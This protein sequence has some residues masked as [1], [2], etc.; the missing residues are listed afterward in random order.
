MHAPPPET[1]TRARH[2][3][4]RRVIGVGVAALPLA[5]LAACGS[6]S[7]SGSAS[8]GIAVEANDT[9]CAPA[10]STGV[11]GTSKFTIKNAGNKVT[12]LYV[13]APGDRVVGEVEQVGPGI[14]RDLTV[15]LQPGSYELACKPG[16]SGDGIRAPFTVTGA[17]AP[18]AGADPRLATAVAQYRSFVIAQSGELVT[19]TQEFAAAV[20]AGDVERAKTLYPT[21]REPWERVEPVA[22]SLGDLDPKID[23]REGDVPAAEW[24]GFHRIE[25]AL[26]VDKNL[27]GMAPVAQALVT[28]VSAVKSGIEKA[29]LTASNLGNGANE[30]LTEVATGKVTGEE[31]RYSHTD[32][33]D[34][35]ANVDGA[36][37]A[38]L[39]LRPVLLD[40]NPAL[41]QQLDTQFAAV[42][43]ALASF[44]R[45]N[46]WELYNALTPEQTKALADRVDALAEPLSRLTAAVLPA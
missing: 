2:L 10:T 41:A 27:D 20:Q 3:P 31:E 28:D 26:W 6:S 16:G 7:S 8:G 40:R 44:E 9:T 1:T 15:E 45:G 35:T 34:F 22:E 36:K 29:D 4:G 42:E 43:S 33:W 30:L 37:Q 32:L 17:A 5:L 39:P 24:G 18:A 12:E 11:A 19:R 46:G 21:T 13:Y 25:K 14:S 23:A 38:Y